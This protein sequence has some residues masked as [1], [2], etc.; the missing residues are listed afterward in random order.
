[1]E[2]L[3][4]HRLQMASD[5]WPGLASHDSCICRKMKMVP[6]T[7]ALYPLHKAVVC[8]LTR[9]EQATVFSVTESWA[10]MTKEGRH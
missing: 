8:G 9:P 7:K 1:M 6:T 2:E 5:L 3:L 10:T 4:F